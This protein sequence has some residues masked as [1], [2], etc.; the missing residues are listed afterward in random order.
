MK[1]PSI[2]L[3]HFFLDLIV[4]AVQQRHRQPDAAGAQRRRRACGCICGSRTA[5]ES[6]QAPRRCRT[7]ASPAMPGGTTTTSWPISF[8]N[9]VQNGLVGHPGLL[10]LEDL[11]LVVPAGLA[12]IRVHAAG[13]VHLAAARATAACSAMRFTA[14]LSSCSADL[15]E[16]RRRP[17]GSECSR[18]FLN[19]RMFLRNSNYLR[20]RVRQPNFA[21]DQADDGAEREHPESDPDPRNQRENVGLN[22]RAL[23]VGRDARRSSR[24]DL[25][26]AGGGW[27]L[28]RSAAGWPCRSAARARACPATVRPA[29]RLDSQPLPGV[30]VVLALLH[31]RRCAGCNGPSW[32]LPPGATSLVTSLIERRAR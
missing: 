31:V 30:V 27:R 26:S 29:R 9:C 24:T 28:P 18:L 25:R 5:P 22:H 21:G 10:H 14:G 7:T 32:K 16:K 19:R 3:F 2:E 11:L 23:V 13:H 8:A 4:I 20:P 15:G 17:A 12:R 1:A 6:D